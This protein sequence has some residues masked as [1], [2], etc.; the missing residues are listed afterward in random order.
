MKG[1]GKSTERVDNPG[2]YCPH[3]TRR[4]R[5]QRCRRDDGGHRVDRGRPSPG[6]RGARPRT[7]WGES[8]PQKIEK[9]SLFV[10]FRH[11]EDPSKCHIPLSHA[12]NT[13]E[14]S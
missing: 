4:G 11:F 1:V 13:K 7:A 8:A 3:P 14:P 2:T 9:P 12:G 6:R 5:A 10:T